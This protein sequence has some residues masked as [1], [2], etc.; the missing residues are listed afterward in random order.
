MTKLDSLSCYEGYIKKLTVDDLLRSTSLG[1]RNISDRLFILD[2][3]DF[4]TL[5]NLPVNKIQVGDTIQITGAGINGTG[6]V[7]SG[8]VTDNGG[9]LIVFSGDPLLYWERIYNGDIMLEWFESE[10]NQT[11]LVKAITLANNEKVRVDPGGKTYTITSQL[12]LPL[13]GFSGGGIFTGANCIW[14]YSKEI[15]NSNGILTFDSLTIDSVWFSSFNGLIRVLGN[16]VYKSTNAFWGVFW[17]NFGDWDIIGEL[18]IDPDAGQSV[19]QNRWGVVHC[20]GLRILSGTV[21]VIRE[22]H[23]NK[24]DSIDTTTANMTAQD[25]STGWH[26]LNES[27][28]QQTNIICSW[29]AEAT[30]QRSIRGNWHILHSNIDGLGNHLVTTERNH[31]LFTN[32]QIERNDGDH[33]AAGVE[34]MAIGGEWDILNS[35]ATAPYCLQTFGTIINQYVNFGIT[36]QPSGID[37]QTTIDLSSAFSGYQINFNFTTPKTVVTGLWYKG[38]DFITTQSD[39]GAF[40]NVTPHVTSSGWKLIRFVLP[41]VTSWIRLFLNTSGTD[42]KL[43]TIGSFFCTLTKTALLPVKKSSFKIR[44]N[45]SNVAIGATTSIPVPLLSGSD[46]NNNIAGRLTVRIKGNAGGP[47][48]VGVVGIWDGL[49]ANSQYTSPLGPA[50]TVVVT[51]L[52]SSLQPINQVGVPT[53]TVTPTT[54]GIDFVVGGVPGDPVDLYWELTPFEHVTF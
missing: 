4:L 15:N 2:V 36:D 28:V 47:T 43:T 32:T 25:S 8:S 1:L 17:N 31:S 26:I 49:V 29:Y 51:E 54:T 35:T 12:F 10:N 37:K 40:T 52:G 16:V 14:Q 38:D 39:G 53:V 6:V 20:G 46:A 34:N 22:A 7:K 9:T 42:Y 33:L 48:F 27:D 13:Y 11:Q 3:I 24:F 19:N 30:G 45:E 5:R 18:Q 23:S 50:G 21:N 44:G 41:N